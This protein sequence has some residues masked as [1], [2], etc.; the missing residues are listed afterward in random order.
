M[1]LVH[2][3]V[4]VGGDGM[5]SEVLNGLVLR[6]QTDARA[7]T[8]AADFEPVPPRTTVGIIPAGKEKKGGRQAGREEKEGKREGVREGGMEGEKEGKREGWKE[9]GGLERKGRE[10]GRQEGR[11]GGRADQEGS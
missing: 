7:N 1:S 10:G 11:E 3:V 8:S 6:A 2:R 9:E 5:F 4:S